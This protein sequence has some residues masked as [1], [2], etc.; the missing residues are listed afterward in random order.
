MYRPGVAPGGFSV[1][2]VVGAGQTLDEAGGG[3]HRQGEGQ[4]QQPH[5]DGADDAGG[6]KGNGQ[7]DDRQQDGAQDAGQ[8]R[9][10]G[11]AGAAA[12]G[13]AQIGYRGQQ[14]RQVYHRHAKGYP[15]EHRCHGDDRRDLQECGDNAQHHA[16]RSGQTHTVPFVLVAE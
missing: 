4:Y 12:G 10:Q 3:G 6:R 13:C 7:Q 14:H 2:S 5:Q 15:Q 1:R 9:R 8:H 16:D 11:R